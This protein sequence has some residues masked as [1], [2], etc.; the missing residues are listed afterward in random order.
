MKASLNI[1]M[2]PIVLFSSCTKDENEYDAIDFKKEMRTFV[3]AI[4]E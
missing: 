2:I 4:S 1:F 3:V